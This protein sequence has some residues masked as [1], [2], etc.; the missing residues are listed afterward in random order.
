[1]K[2]VILLSLIFISMAFVGFSQDCYTQAANKPSTYASN[3]QN[4]INPIGKPAS[5]D[6][7]KMK[8]QL[9]K[10]ESWMRTTLNGFTGAKLMYGNNYFFDPGGTDFLYK[11]TGL[12]GN[13]QAIMMFFAYYCYENKNTIETEGESGSNLKVDINNVFTSGLCSDVGVFTINGKQA[14][15]VL[16]K[17]STEGR[18]DY[19]DLRKRMNFND[20]VYTS[21]TDLFLIRNSD[22]PVF[23]SL[24]RKEYLQQLL[25]DVEANMIK[26]IASAKAEYTPVAEAANKLNFDEE[27][28][29]M[30]NSKNYTPEQMAPY[31]KRFI[32]TWETEK[33]KYDKR[34]AYT[35]TESAKVKEVLLEYLKKPE[36]WLG[37]GFGTFFSNSY[38]EKG[39]KSYL[40]HLDIY[41]ESKEDYTR[42][43][44]VSINPDYF[45]NALSMDVPQLILLTLNKNGYLYMHKLAE[46]IK[47]P[48]ALTPLE[49]ILTPG[50]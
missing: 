44:V 38:T 5:W 12:K 27:L 29:R 46:M 16:E 7:S 36:E 30:D 40:D 18:F 17:N 8:P 42:S 37:S 9:A 20:T 35:E 10:V 4:F 11:S 48:G 15:R 2:K 26:D 43:E 49:A 47:K 33:Q 3:F 39:I 23:I 41:T 1:M 19:Y 21:K 14:F 24:T 25:K 13:C 6:I 34:I 50:N 28:K 31:R 22:K 32:E 45:N